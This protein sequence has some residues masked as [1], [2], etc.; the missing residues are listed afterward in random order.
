M[1]RV[2]NLEFEYKGKT[3]SALVSR[4]KKEAEQS[5]LVQIFDKSLLRIFPAGRLIFSKTGGIKSPDTAMSKSKQD[6]V[7]C[8]MK[9]IST[10]FE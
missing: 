5:Y 8:I 6:L 7:Q 4:Y 9:K 1:G 2:Y 3:H 10:D